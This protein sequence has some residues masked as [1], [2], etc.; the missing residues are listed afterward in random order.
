LVSLYNSMAANDY[1]ILHA[2]LNAQVKKG[3]EGSIFQKVIKT[4]QF[5]SILF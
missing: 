2:T 5:Y 4:R 3:T 1:S